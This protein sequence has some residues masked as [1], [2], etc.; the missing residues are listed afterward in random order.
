MASL[1][2][3]V[4]DAVHGKSA[5]DVRVVLTRIA[6]DGSRHEVANARTDQDGRINIPVEIDH[7]LT[8]NIT[9]LFEVAFDTADYFRQQNVLAPQD[10]IMQSVVVRIAMTEAGK[11]YHIPIMASPH[12][13][14]IWWSA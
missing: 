5:T 14:S 6:V 10:Q 3:H 8:G 13:Y 1:T 7:N 9:S 4:L 11:R 2:S 12:S